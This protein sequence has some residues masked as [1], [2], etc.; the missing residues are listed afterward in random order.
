MTGATVGNGI[1]HNDGE[2]L[3]P[4]RLPVLC[5]QFDEDDGEGSGGERLYAVQA[6]SSAGIAFTLDDDALK[7]SG[8]ILHAPD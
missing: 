7:E 6:L 1:H 2:D 4:R 8:F 3:P 5:A